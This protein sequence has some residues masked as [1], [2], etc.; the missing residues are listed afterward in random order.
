M[1]RLSSTQLM[2]ALPEAA[3]AHLPPN[4]RKFK[5]V[6]RSWLCQLYYR[7]PQ[8]HYEVW[9]QGEQRGRVEVGLHF[10]S[11]D[12]AENTRLLRGFQRYLI[13]V[14]ANL[15]DHWEAEQ[16]TK[17]WTK[18]YVVVKYE[19]FTHAYLEEIAACLAQAIV[20]LQPMFEEIYAAR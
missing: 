9:N 2:Q 14:K 12:P 18:V 16:W 20:V 13:E 19:P 3:R 1:A 7:N 8:L 15:G 6:T 11:R 5:T 10:E 4:L 17:S